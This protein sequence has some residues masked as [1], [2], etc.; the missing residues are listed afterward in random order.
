VD[1]LPVSLPRDPGDA[2]EIGRVAA[3]VGARE[4]LPEGLLSRAA[5]GGVDVARVDGRLRVEGR[6][7]ASPHDRDA[8]VPL[9]HRGGERDG[10]A[11][12]RPRHDREA[13]EGVG[14]TIEVGE[15]G[16][17][18]VGV[19]VPVHEGVLPLPFEDRA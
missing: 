8:R 14:R 7:V 9:A 13:D 17:G 12:L 6:E 16:P 5:D 15:D 4:D 19:E 1:D 2:G 3:V 18:G 11:D 10:R